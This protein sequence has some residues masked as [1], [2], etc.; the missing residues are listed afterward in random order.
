MIQNIDIPQI[1]IEGFC[2]RWNIEEL[3]LFGSVLRSDFKGDSDVDVL[4][5]FAPNTRYTFA[6][7]M[8]M[9]EEL[10]ALLGRRID[11]GTR[12]S[13]EEDPN[14]I[15]RNAILGSAQVIYAKR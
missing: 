12:R 7:I 11:L 14:Y 10:S 8:Q 4:V 1:E 13:V 6:E 15:R 9:E 2:R 5:T 3:A